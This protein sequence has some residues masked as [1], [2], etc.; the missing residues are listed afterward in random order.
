MKLGAWGEPEAGP[1]TSAAL[2]AGPSTDG[3]MCRSTINRTS[4]GNRA[5]PDYRP[6]KSKISF[7]YRNMK[8]GI[9]SFK[10]KGITDK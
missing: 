10:R 6:L 4:K 1:H 2:G 8:N 9:K 7:M 3:R 5:P